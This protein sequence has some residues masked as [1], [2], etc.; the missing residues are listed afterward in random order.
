MASLFWSLARKSRETLRTALKIP[1][2][3]VFL[4]TII[5]VLTVLLSSPIATLVMGCKRNTI[6]RVCHVQF[7]S[8]LAVRNSKTFAAMWA[9]PS[10]ES[11]RCFHRKCRGRAVKRLEVDVG[12]LRQLGWLQTPIQRYAECSAVARLCYC[13]KFETVFTCYLPQEPYQCVIHVASDISE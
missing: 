6:P 2:L 1:H 9:A 5:R 12:L 7:M 4:L 13:A 11:S 8:K 3:M 10:L